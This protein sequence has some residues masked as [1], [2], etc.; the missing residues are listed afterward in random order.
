M[1]D[2]F[3]SYASED[4]SRVRRLADALSGHGWSVWWDRQIQAGKT[5]DHVI[6]EALESARCVV[7]VWSRDSVASSWVREEAD[8]GRKRGVLIPVLIDEISPPLGFGRIQAA[9]MIEWDGAPESEAFQKLV[10]DVTALIDAPSAARDPASETAAPKAPE[11]V[12]GAAQAVIARPEVSAVPRTLVHGRTAKLLLAGAVMV[13]LLAVAIYQMVPRGPD[14]S[15]SP[16][17][18]AE[19]TGLRLSAVLTDGGEPL[20][21]GVTY[22]VYTA[23]RDAGGNR[24]RVTGSNQ[25]YEAAWFALPAGRYFVTA[26]YGSASANVEVEVTPAGVS[27]QILNLRAGILQLTAVL[28]DGGEPLARDVAYEVYAAARDAEGN[29]KRVTG[30]NL[31]NEAARFVLPAGR[32]FVTAA[33]GSASANVEVEVTPAGVSQQILNL[34]AGILRLT[35]VLADGGK[36]V[37]GVVYEVYAAARDAE[38]NRKRVTRSSLPNEAARFVLPAGRYF[39]TAAYGSASANVEVE[40]TPAGVSEQIL[41]LR[42][43]ILRLT[44]VLADGGKALSNADYVVYAAARDAE[45]NRKQVTGTNLPNESARFVLPAGRY[46]VTAAHSGGNASAETVVTAGGTKDVQLRIVPVTKR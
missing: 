22:E 32:Y 27:Q 14:L 7:V 42:A 20:A 45:G 36:A 11:H 44:A 4:R 8:E 16:P 15:E 19:A 46:F 37:S 38:G 40:V 9:R 39:V 26:A 33:Y 12:A 21:R 28:A 10:A 13:A 17:P 3:I 43:G 2:I 6:A 31:P 29:R 41:N 1:S 23:V 24:K 25:P 5:F 35:A 34:R 30:S 18:P